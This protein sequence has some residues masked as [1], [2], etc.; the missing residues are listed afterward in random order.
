MNEQDHPVLT[1]S[2]DKR[3]AFKL[4]GDGGGSL[5][6]SFDSSQADVIGV[7]YKQYRE[8]VLHAAF[9]KVPD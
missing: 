9:I 7:L 8:C 1:C 2:I 4:D 5:T 6:I 3:G